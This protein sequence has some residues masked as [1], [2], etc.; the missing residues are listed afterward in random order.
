MP[1]TKEVQ[2]R[3]IPVRQVEP[4]QIAHSVLRRSLTRPLPPGF[5]ISMRNA[6]ERRRRLNMLIFRSP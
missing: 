2:G 4:R 6:A 5:P 1:A 3:L